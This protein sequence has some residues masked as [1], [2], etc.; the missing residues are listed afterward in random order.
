MLE[1]VEQG[2]LVEEDGAEGEALCVGEA[3]GGDRAVAV[4]DA[5][6]LAVEVLDGVRAESWKTRRTSTPPSVCG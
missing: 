5:L 6:E 1:A 4:E 3:A 2:E